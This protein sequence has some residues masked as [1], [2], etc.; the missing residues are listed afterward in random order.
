MNGPTSIAKLVVGVFLCG[1]LPVET[2]LRAAEPLAANVVQYSQKY[3]LECHSGAKPKGEL[4]LGRYENIGD[5]TASFRRWNNIVEFVRSGEMPPEESKQPTIQESNEFVEAIEAILSEAAKKDAGDPGVVLPRRLSNTEYDLSVFAL[6][7][8][9][10]RPT[11]DFPADPAGGEGFDNTG[12]ALGMSPNLLKKYLSAAERIADHLVVKTDGITFAPFPVTSYNER[13]KLTEQAI[14]DFYES[15]EIDTRA[16]VEAAWRFRYR[17]GDQQDVTI[18]QWAKNLG[19]SPKYL[20]LVWLT[21]S[22]PPKQAVFLSDI[23]EAWE[24]LPPPSDDSDDNSTVPNEL[25]SLW[26]SIEFGRR[27]LAPPNQQL[28]RSNA[29]NWPI[30]HLDFRAK[31]A[32]ARDKFDRTNLKHET[33]LNNVRVNAPAANAKAYSVYVRFER[34]FADEGDFVIVKRPLFSHANHLPNNEADEKNHQVQSL[35]SVLETPH[36]EL[37]EKLKFGQH[38]R[39]GEIDPEWFVVQTPATIQIP[40]TVE[41]QKELNG[42]HLLLPCTLDGKHSKDGS[43]LIQCSLGEAPKSKF[44]NNAQHLIYSDGQAATALA[45]SAAVFCNTFPNRFFYADDRRGLAAGFHL[46]EGFFRD[47]QPLVEKV[48]SDREAAELNRLWKELDFVTQAAETLLRGFVWFERSEREVLHDERFDFLRPEDPELVTDGLLSK[49]EK[50]YLDKMGI[51]RLGDSLKPENPSERYE[52]IHGF[53]DEIRGGLRRQNEL[54]IGAEQRALEDL[55]TLTSQAYRRPLAVDEQKKLLALYSQLRDEGQGVEQAVRG[56]L[57]AVLM[58][59]DF[60]YRYRVAP[61]GKGVYPLSGDELASRL[62]YFLWSSLPDEE[63]LVAARTGRLQS[64]EELAKQSRRMIKDSRIDSFAREFFGQWLRYRDFLD[65]DPIHA[66]AF[67]GYD[68]SLRQAMIEEPTRL[69]TH[70][71]TSD[72]PLTHLINSDTTFVNAVLA[73]HYGGAIETQYRALAGASRND[74]S[75]APPWKMVS[76]LKAEG[77]GGMLG[78]AVILTTNS[79]GERTSPVKRGFWSVHHLL[80]QHFPPPPADVP[81]L[82]DSD[83]VAEKSLRELLKAH[84]AAPQCALCHTHFD[85]L[86]LA[87]EGFDP[88]GRARKKDGA[89]RPVDNQAILP[90]GKSAQGIPALI[91]YIDEH[92]RQDFVRTLCRKFLGYALGRSVKLSDGPLLAKMERE[93]KANDYRFSVLF[94]VVVRS[95]QF[96]MQRGRDFSITANEYSIAAWFSVVDLAKDPCHTGSL[97]RSTTVLPER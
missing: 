72:K 55:Q 44:N 67:P 32:A 2:T 76:G 36:P 38:P 54:M 71:I 22:E 94:E 40:I 93:L 57:V 16:Y 97:A 96:R 37:V 73:K 29:G 47:D 59:P 48:L 56:V 89:G 65:N 13:K 14:I 5:I 39:D 42:K 62:S 63:L 27:V 3:C 60:C 20:K 25:N 53:F 23:R 74:K 88:I 9:D 86:G 90:N 46:V 30:S 31:T 78:M 91:E 28:I 77:R 64:E 87:M 34:G 66:A 4:D 92:R 69:A 83:K 26:Q 75:S 19:L 15:R 84:V 18:Q 85:S 1:F 6:T 7:G 45:D 10:I 80:G 43:V 17:A 24:A 41:M 21:L 95:E 51:K 50:L 49:F 81:E 61:A 68:D 33:L 35:R 70:L 12:E 11:R 52:M 8:V 82:P 79:A 58:S